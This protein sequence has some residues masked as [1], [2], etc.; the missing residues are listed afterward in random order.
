[1]K[2]SM[3][4]N[5]LQFKELFSITHIENTPSDNSGKGV[6]DCDK[7]IIDSVYG[8]NKEISRDDALMYRYNRENPISLFEKNQPERAYQASDVPQEFIDQMNRT[9]QAQWDQIRL[10]FALDFQGDDIEYNVER[11]AAAYAAGVEHLTAHFSGQQL[12]SYLQELKI[13]V[14]AKKQSM[15][16]LYSNKVGGFL[17]ENGG[18]GEVEKVYRTISEAYDKKVQQ[19]TAFIQ[20][21]SDYAK[22]EGSADSWLKDDVAYM[23][24]ELRKAYH[25]QVPGA[26]EIGQSGSRVN[27]EGNYSLQEITLA[28][29]FID[30]MRR[31][32]VGTLSSNEERIGLEVG[33]AQLK[34]TLFAEQSGVS[35]ALAQQMKEA[36]NR[37]LEKQIDREN[38]WILA[39]A[40]DPYFDIE[41]NPPFDKAEI[42]DVSS[43][44]LL[45]YQREGNYMKAILEGISYAKDKSAQKTAGSRYGALE[46]YENNTVW[47]FFFDNSGIINSPI[48]QSMYVSGMDQRS[49]FEKLADSWNEFAFRLTGS[50]IYI[51]PQ[52]AAGRG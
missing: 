25:A 7:L 15:A 45:Y 37:Y 16:Q 34:T 4:P 44:L 21:N 18:S 46:R 22:L 14:E 47:K 26:E 11:L 28:S 6:S 23:A 13:A 36:V 5:Y 38:N 41:K 49:D 12:D 9:G 27:S 31:T 52:S 17:E 35:D 33:I 24:Q 32:D 19:Y 43:R 1:M 20:I 48:Y 10:R 40:D 51:L 3:N 50:Q 39:H 2:I 30:E 29:R 42:Y 8:G